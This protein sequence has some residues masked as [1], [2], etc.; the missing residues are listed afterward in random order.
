MKKWIAGLLITIMVVTSGMGTVS[1]EG[2]HENSKL[3]VAVSL[4]SVKMTLLNKSWAGST[5][6]SMPWGSSLTFK[7]EVGWDDGIVARDDFA[8]VDWSVTDQAGRPTQ[9]WTKT[10][11]DDWD[12]VAAH[13][14]CPRIANTV[15]QILPI[16]FVS[17]SLQM[18]AVGFL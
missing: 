13:P 16:R 18:K 14:I 6:N 1:A 10:W 12:G 9:V 5:E 7:A 3:H 2:N 15:C 8:A 4:N 11:F 17:F